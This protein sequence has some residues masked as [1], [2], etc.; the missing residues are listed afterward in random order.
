[1]DIIL[2]VLAAIAGFAV[3]LAVGIGLMAILTVFAGP[4][5]DLEY[6]SDDDW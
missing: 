1:M 6:F 4:P 2:W 5:D 3:V